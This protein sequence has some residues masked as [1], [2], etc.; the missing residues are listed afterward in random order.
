MDKV[1]VSDVG[2]RQ[3][4]LA[5]TRYEKMA[6]DDRQHFLDRARASSK[7]TIPF[8]VPDEGANS[9]SEYP[10]PYQSVGSR[11]VNNLASKLLL[12]LFPPNTPFHRFIIDKFKLSPEEKVQE[13]LLTTVESA[14]S[15]VEQAIVAEFETSAARTHLFE[16]LKHSIV[17]GNVLLYVPPKDNIKVYHLDR[18]V[19]E[20]DP[21]GNVMTIIVKETISKKLLPPEVLEH[22]DGENSS[23]DDD[24]DT[25]FLIERQQNGSW[26]VHQETSKGILIGKKGSYPKNKNPWI[27]L[28]FSKIDGE[29]YGRG[30]VEELLGDLISLEGLTQ[31]IVEGSAAAAKVLFLVNE[32][33]T[34]RV[35]NLAE[36]PNGG[37]VNGSEQDISVLQLNKLADF[38]VAQET[39]VRIQ[40]N[41]EAAFLLNS[42]V[43]RSGERVTAEE[44]RFLAQELSD[45]LGG[46]YSILAEELQL[47]L[48]SALQERMRKGKRLPP[49]P[50]DIVKTT[51]VTGLDALGR[52]H[53]LNKLDL[54]IGGAIQTFGTEVVGKFINLG[55][56]FTRRG[57]ALGIDTKGLVKDEEAVKQETQQTQ[58]QALAER[59]G[60]EALKQV[61][62]VAQQNNQPDTPQQPQE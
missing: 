60:P 14:L 46:I 20:R 23:D 2:V 40:A 54:F 32:N 38:R 8:I 13:D 57:T 48:V 43:Q 62:Q 17:A 39:I 51:I 44:I 47:P 4:G 11:G 61:G 34:T 6:S 59:L 37:F 21:M 28:R 33:G 15:D 7:L 10:Q 9:S 1:E 12:A 42:S 36:A 19:V 52:G 18:Y 55:D 56:Y 27:A 41:L 50:K 45:A 26:S 53:D 24:V 49:I 16:A 31:A 25:Y 58:L 35:K 22:S 29:N 3:E 30:Y 5:S